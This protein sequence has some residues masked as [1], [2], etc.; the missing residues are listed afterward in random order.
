[1]DLILPSLSK[2]IL[3]CTFAAETSWTGTATRV[4]NAWSTLI[5]CD[6]TVLALLLSTSRMLHV[7]GRQSTAQLEGFLQSWNQEGLRTTKH[8]DHQDNTDDASM[9]IFVKLR[10]IWR[11]KSYVLMSCHLLLRQF[12]GRKQKALGW[13]ACSIQLLSGVQNFN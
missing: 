12:S 11:L 7:V 13:N 1:M 5:C 6:L 9:V 8:T 3:M 4:D 2:N 10:E